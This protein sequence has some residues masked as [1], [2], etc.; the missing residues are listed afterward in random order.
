MWLLCDT[1]M[2][3]DAGLI[4]FQHAHSWFNMMHPVLLPCIIV[5]NESS[6]L[7]CSASVTVRKFLLLVH[8]I[9]G[10]DARDGDD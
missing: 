2:R 10:P 9:S 3:F 6:V 7:L 5:N 1:G 8:G 4:Q